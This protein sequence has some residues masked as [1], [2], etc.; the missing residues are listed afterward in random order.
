MKQTLSDHDR[1]RLDVRVAETE[2]RTGTQIVLTV[3]QRS[4]SYAE[5]PWKAFALG[6]SAAGLALLLL[7]WRLYDWYPDVPPLVMVVGIL[8]S[9]ALLALLSAVIPRFARLFLSDYRAEVEVQQYAKALFLDRELFATQGRRG[10][11]LLV[12]LF[13]HR[14]VIL[15]DKGLDERFK[16]DDVKN[17]I[18]AMTPLL[19]RRQVVQAFDAGLDYLSRILTTTSSQVHSD[20]LPN[21]IIEEEGI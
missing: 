9:G 16:E 20:E 1:R 6:A 5:L 14:V 13:E 15:P 8:A 18:A 2:K 21:E 10:F 7:H 19:K 12:S 11:L 3:I 17:M 4:D